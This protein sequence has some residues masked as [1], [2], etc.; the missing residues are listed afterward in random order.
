ME[1]FAGTQ[2]A[3]MGAASFGK[4]FDDK[5]DG[6]E[7]VRMCRALRVLNQLRYFTVRRAARRGARGG[8]VTG[9][10]A[11]QVGMPLTFKQYVGA[12][13][14]CIHVFLGV[15]AIAFA[16]GARRYEELGEEV[17]VDRLIHRHVST[18][19]RGQS[20]IG[21]ARACAHVD[22]RRGRA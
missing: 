12:A 6:D 21:G 8:C 22:G 18:R 4:N 3:L 13:G 2:Q 9:A 7:F 11:A 10:R 20:R 5:F 16:N 19:A 17:V 15:F 1:F 14:M